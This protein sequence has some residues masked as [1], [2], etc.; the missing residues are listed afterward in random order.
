MGTVYCAE[1][2]V[3]QRPVALKVINPELLAD[4]AAVD[5]FMREA[6]AAACLNH[7]NVVAVHDAETAGEGHF[8]VM[9]FVAGTDLAQVVRR[10]GPLPVGRACDYIRQ[11]A[12][13]LQHA[14]EHGM[15]HRDITPRNLMVADEGQIKVLDFG[16]AQFVREA[17]SRDPSGAPAALLGSVDFMAPEQAVDP[18]SADVR[19]DV[20][21][22][23][24]TLFFLLTGR[25]PFPAATLREKLQAHAEQRRR[26]WRVSA[27][28]CPRN[29]RR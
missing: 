8:L 7:P 10:E 20:Y 16:L 24:C 27:A 9:E 25:P 17:R 1:H 5:R 22:L 3:L 12:A 23:G 11:A 18:H 21:G 29:C 19:A 15:V 2:R 28:T 6:R 26:R 13:G 4:A 14:H